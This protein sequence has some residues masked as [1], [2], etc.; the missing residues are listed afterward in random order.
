MALWS[1]VFY[2]LLLLFPGFAKAWNAQG[3]ALIATLAFHHLSPKAKTAFFTYNEAFN[4]SSNFAFKPHRFSSSAVWLDAYTYQ[5]PGLPWLKQ[6]H[7]IDQPF[8]KK[9]KARPCF[10]AVPPTIL[11]MNAVTA[12]EKA[13]K[14]VSSKEA[15]Q[16]EKGFY[17]R[18][19]LHV[20][21]DLHQ[22]LHAISQYSPQYPAG[23]Q[24]GNAVRLGSNSIA[25]NL[26]AYWDRGG[27]FLKQRPKKRKK[28]YT[29]GLLEKKANQLERK[30]PCQL[31][32]MNLA[33]ES[34][35]LES[36][37]LAIQEAYAV[38]AF[39]KPSKA[40]QSRVKSRSQAQIALAAC[41][42]AAV[43][44]HCLI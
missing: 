4:R 37:R 12:I 18:I 44:N 22:P 14:I 27:G 9:G 25:K 41:R 38:Q 19:L 40:Y 35:A 43:L 3:H 28:E 26:H 13:K 23:D 16:A 33:P 30:W 8:F 17:L 39:E 2:L 29:Q 11:P 36:Y 5:N 10:P 15:S 42:L 1:I 7:Y 6:I 31:D 24:G 32:K 21:G 34:W 20:V